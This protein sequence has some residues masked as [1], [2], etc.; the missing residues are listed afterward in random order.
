M[1]RGIRVRELEGGPATHPFLGGFAFISEGVSSVVEWVT[2][3]TFDPYPSDCGFAR[4]FGEE[5]FGE[6]N[7]FPVAFWSEFSGDHTVSPFAV[8]VEGDCAGR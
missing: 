8:I 4:K 2:G 1:V 6:R 5:M 7:H 3:V